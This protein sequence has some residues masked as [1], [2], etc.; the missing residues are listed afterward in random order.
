MEKHQLMD[1]FQYIQYFHYII[2][3]LRFVIDRRPWMISSFPNMIVHF[4]INKHRPKLSTIIAIHFR[5][6]D[7]HIE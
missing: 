4:M 1:I 6:S 3:L 2:F 7:T 5:S